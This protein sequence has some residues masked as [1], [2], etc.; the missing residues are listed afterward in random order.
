MKTASLR[1]EL[2][3][4]GATP[5]PAADP[6]PHSFAISVWTRRDDWL[7]V[8]LFLPVPVFLLGYF[9]P[10][11]GIPAAVLALAA[12]VVVRPFVAA[13]LPGW[14]AKPLTGAFLV[15][16]FAAGWTSLGGAGH[17]FYANEID[18]GTRYAVLRDLVV[19]DWPPRYLDES[20]NE[21]ILRAPLGYYVVPALLGKIA[22]IAW[23]DLILLSWTWLGVA[24]FFLANVGGTPLRRIWVLI[25]FAIASGMDIVGFLWTSDGYLPNLGYHIEWWTGRMKYSSNSTMLYWIPNHVIP[26]WIL[27]AWLWRFQASADFL[28]RLPLI[29]LA[30]VTWSP[31][32]MVGAMPMIAVMVWQARAELRPRMSELWRSLLPVLFPALLISAY[33]LTSAGQIKSW[34]VVSPASTATGNGFDWWLGT[35]I[36]ILFEVLIFGVFAWQSSRSTILA[37]GLLL[38]CLLPFFGFGPTNDLAT[39]GAIPAL[40]VMWLTL[41]NEL[42]LP[43]RQRRLSTGRRRLLLL[44]LLVGAATPFQESYR[45]VATKRW[46]PDQSKPVPVPLNGFPAHYFASAARPLASMLKQTE[47]LPA[48]AWHRKNGR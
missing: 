37:A 11:L 26:G 25:L 2:F 48:S 17:L 3:G 42:S 20:G 22:G 38:L 14:G 21:F 19:N 47:A 24:L 35:F 31:L 12:F 46:D 23:A 8:Y 18:W 10:W 16:G 15:L 34:S 36:F 41:I 45:A 33:L 9:L 1:G 6:M 44:L 28:R 30:V 29:G 4:A 7:L 43:Y 39:L 13:S 27:G 5:A 32:P 40:T